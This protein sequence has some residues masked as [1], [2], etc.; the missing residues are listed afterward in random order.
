[1]RDQPAKRLRT[2]LR[3]LL[4]LTPMAERSPTGSASCDLGHVVINGSDPD[5]PD[6]VFVR[7]RMLDGEFRL[8]TE[9]AMAC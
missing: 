1:M 3:F 2:Q 8:D 4:R 6:G 7:W 9:P 5:R